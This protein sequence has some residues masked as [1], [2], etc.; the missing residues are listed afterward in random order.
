MCLATEAL[1]ET[2]LVWSFGAGDWINVSLCMNPKNNI[3]TPRDVQGREVSIYQ[4]IVPKLGAIWV[5]DEDSECMK[6]IKK[7]K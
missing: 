4:A 5:L 3:G 6:S 2:L 7:E 1:M